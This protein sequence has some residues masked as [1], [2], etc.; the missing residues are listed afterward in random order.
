MAPKILIVDDDPLMRQL[1][2][3]HLI[4]AGYRLIAADNA[5]QA[6][7]LAASEV[8]QV[9][10]MDMLMPDMDGLTALR[11][12]KKNKATRAIPVVVI[13]GNTEYQIS[14]REAEGAGAAFFLSKPFSPKQLL[15]HL[16]RLVSAKPPEVPPDKP[17]P[18]K[19]ITGPP[20]PADL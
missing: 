18:L 11:Q 17:P 9:I 7:K 1:Y 10:I 19:G 2:E 3:R 5:R 14:Q 12:L 15:D 6:L 20:S 16:Q 8:P 4:N 13:S